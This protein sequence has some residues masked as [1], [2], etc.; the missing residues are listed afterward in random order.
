[1][2]P[3]VL[4]WSI[5]KPDGV[6]AQEQPE[7]GHSVVLGIVGDSE[8]IWRGV[9]VERK[10]R[11]LRW[12]GRSWRKSTESLN[13]ASVGGIK[14]LVVIVW[15]HISQLVDMLTSRTLPGP[16]WQV[17]RA[18]SA[19]WITLIQK[20]MIMGLPSPKSSRAPRLRLTL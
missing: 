4:S 11:W 1:M 6:S 9:D 13:G 8:G 14:D 16:D 18:D 19:E 20:A 3:K 17:C 5:A 10:A 12:I 2:P 7:G 15:K